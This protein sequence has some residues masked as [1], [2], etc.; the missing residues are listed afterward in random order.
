M[1]LPPGFLGTEADLLIDTVVCS[2]GAILPIMGYAL[3]LVR[4]GRYEAHRNVMAA[5]FSLL[6]V[7]VMLFE[8][9]LSAH[10]GIFALTAD[11]AFAGTT[12][13]KAS[14]YVHTSFSFSTALIWLGLVPTSLLRMRPPRPTPATSWHR[15]LGKL[16]MALMTGTCLTGLELYIVGF[17]Y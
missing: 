3:H 16:G 1:D 2:L 12:L 7:V 6:L 14:V 10:G 11:S 17:G 9:D 5:L 8:A 4:Q 13:L 15:N